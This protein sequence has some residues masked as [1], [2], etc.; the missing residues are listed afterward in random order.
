MAHEQQHQLLLRVLSQN[1]AAGKDPHQVRAMLANGSAGD[2][3]AR[4]SEGRTALHYAAANNCPLSVIKALLNWGAMVNAADDAGLTRLHV[5][6]MR[7][8]VATGCLLLDHG[9]DLFARD[10]EGRTPKDRRRLNA[11]FASTWRCTRRISMP[12]PCRM[13]S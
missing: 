6:C 13:S 8:N 3:M 10:K 2:V 9:A 12:L 7:A 4:D 1:E 5:F 11:H